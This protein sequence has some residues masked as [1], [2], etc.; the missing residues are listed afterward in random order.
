MLLLDKNYL[1]TLQKKW[2][3]RFCPGAPLQKDKK[4][5]LNNRLRRHNTLRTEG[6]N[7]M[8][9]D[10]NCGNTNEMKI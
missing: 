3:K 8:K 10:V 4:N 9:D 2:E 7:E 1:V 5:G 6:I